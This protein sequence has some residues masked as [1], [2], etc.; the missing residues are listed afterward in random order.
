MLRSFTEGGNHSMRLE[1]M[2]YIVEISDTGSFSLASERLYISQPSISQSVTALEKELNVTIFNRTRNGVI[3]TEIGTCIIDHA[4][5]ILHEINEIQKMSSI[6]NE[7]VIA[8]ITIGVLPIF[9]NNVIPKIITIFRDTYPRVTIKVIESGTQDIKLQLKKG[10]LD[11][12]I[13]SQH[14]SGEFEPDLYTFKPLI[15]GKLMCYV[16]K[17]SPLATNPKV[18]FADLVKYPVVLFGEGYS[19][20]NYLYGKLSEWG[21]PNILSSINNPEAIK[22]IVMQTDAIGFGPD[23][24]LINDSNVQSG[25]LILLN[26]E[27]MPD[28]QFGILSNKK[29]STNAVCESLIEIITIE[30]ENF[31]QIL[32]KSKVW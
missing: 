10:A 7:E 14:E 12:G 28:T 13:V 27:S 3:P 26:I 20:Q 17:Q 15:T 30:A 24:S 22:K 23:I 19:L 18:S 1:Q 8:T 5:I 9:N 21:S 32:L 11:L 29:R 31:K 25:D 4:R 16:S 2:H 6:G